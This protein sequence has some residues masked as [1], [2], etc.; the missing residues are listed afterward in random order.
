MTFHADLTECKIRVVKGWRLIAIGWLDYDGERL[1]PFQREKPSPR[2]KER[3]VKLVECRHPLLIVRP[4][5]HV[6]NVPPCRGMDELFYKRLETG[7]VNDVP[8]G[9]G[10]MFVRHRTE[11]NALYCAPSLVT[12][13]VS[14]HWY[15]P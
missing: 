14:D 3:L 10:E 9:G 4:G 1:C 12:H 13:Y 7:P 5:L 15:R 8:M 2:L 6:C 11:A